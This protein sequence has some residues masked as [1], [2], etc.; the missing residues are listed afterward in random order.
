[1][2]FNFSNNQDRAVFEKALAETVD[3]YGIDIQ[4][5]VVTFDHDKDPLY[6]EDTKPLVSAKYNM[7]A[8]G[9]LIQED[10]LLSR[11]GLQ[12]ED[13]IELSLSKAKF[14]EIV[15]E[16]T[17][18]KSGD[19]VI[20]NYMNNRIFTVAEA[21]EEDNVFLQKK[22]GWRL[23]LQAADLV[24]EE[25]TPD[26]GVDDIELEPP[27]FDDN[28]LIES[29]DDDVVVNDPEEESPWGEFG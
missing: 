25:V 11:F 24:G 29:L 10:F 13:S 22:F 19:K 7:K 16:D 18:P 2:S 20:I 28:D 21:K 14:E 8:Y 3:I 26:I 17:Y 5:L 9:E 27:V 6:N 12:S 23:I 1:M 4:Y 15:G